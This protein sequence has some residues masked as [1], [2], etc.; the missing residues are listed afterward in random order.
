MWFDSRVVMPTSCARAPSRARARWASSD[1]T[2]TGLY[3]P[4]RM[5]CAS[6]SASFWSVLFICIFERS[7][8]VPGVETGDV[9]TAR[10]QFMHEPRR[11]RPGLDPKLGILSRMPP[12]NPRY[13]LRV[14][15]TLATPKPGAGVVNNTDRSQLL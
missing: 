12:D 5:I 15:R 7:T 10:A 4:V 8:R 6:P 1:L 3:H 14:S 9:E 13:P 11:H 2:C